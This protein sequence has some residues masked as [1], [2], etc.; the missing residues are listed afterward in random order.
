MPE[1]RSPW[2]FTP[3]V[4]LLTVGGKDSEVDEGHGWVRRAVAMRGTRKERER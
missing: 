1:E 3:V 2:N 4:E